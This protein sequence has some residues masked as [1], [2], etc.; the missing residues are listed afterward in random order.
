MMM[1]FYVILLQ[2]RLSYLCKHFEVSSVLYD[3][4]P[5]PLQ[6]FSSI[7]L[8][9]LYNIQTYAS[10]Q[11]TIRTPLSYQFILVLISFLLIIH[12]GCFV[13]LQGG[14]GTLEN[15]QVLQVRFLILS[16]SLCFP[17]EAEPCPWLRESCNMFY[18]IVC[19][20][21]AFFFIKKICWYIF[22][23]I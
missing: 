8:S 3:Y 17:F 4:N 15:C 18:C 22:F 16:S 7:P 1:N 21:H 10:Q 2:T 13:K 14:E 23:I 5:T 11:K 6:F 9:S 19:L 20:Q 12:L